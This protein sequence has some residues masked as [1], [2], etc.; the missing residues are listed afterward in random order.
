[1]HL[2]ESMTSDDKRE[3]KELF[4]LFA[5]FDTDGSGTISIQ[6][7]TQLFRNGEKR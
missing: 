5:D 2:N 3:Y 4:E 6:V 7:K 1:M